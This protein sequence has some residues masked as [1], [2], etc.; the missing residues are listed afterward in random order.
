MRVRAVSWLKTNRLFLCFLIVYSLLWVATCRN[1]FFWD[2]VQLA[3][4]HAWW[5][6]DQNFA[7]LLLPDS[8]DSGHIPFTGFYLALWWK[9]AG[10]GLFVSHLAMLPFLV[11]IVWQATA[12]VKRFFSA[13][14]QFFALAFVL[15]DPTLLAQSVLVSPDIPLLFFFLWALRSLLGQRYAALA[16]ALTGLVL[17]S[18][19]GM[20]VAVALCSFHLVLALR[21]RPLRA[22]A[23]AGLRVLIPYLPA[24]LIGLAYLALHYH[25]KGWIGY[26][27]NSPWAAFFQP[28]SPAGMVH[29]MATLVWRL[30]DFGRVF[31][32]L[33]FPL[34]LWFY[35]RRNK[36]TLPEFRE[37]LTLLVLMGVM[38]SVSM[39]Y[40]TGLNGHRYLLPVILCLSWFTAWLLLEGGLLASRSRRTFAILALIGL[41]GGNLWIYP[42][43]ISQGWDASLAHLPFYSLHNQMI[44]FLKQRNI[45]LHEVGTVAPVDVPLRYLIATDDSSSLRYKDFDNQKYIIESNV[46]NDFTDQELDILWKH[47]ILLKEYRLMGVY[48]RLYQNPEWNGTND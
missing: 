15:L 29:N 24:A 4:R 19:R 3:S 2:T 35:L 39:I 47:W 13:G 37:L 18:M 48:T 34:L 1:F 31:L 12:L 41:L 22:W 36:Q 27:T 30:L 6:Y 45:P 20:M 40:Y 23:Q 9:V 14:S 17:A 42:P 43:R 5:F 26:H 32:Y 25:A 16:F 28:A 11:G 38:L 7:T 21:G 33:L 10:P 46:N 44:T 8:M